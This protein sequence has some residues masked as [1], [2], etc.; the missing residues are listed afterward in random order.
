MIGPRPVLPPS[1]EPVHEYV[2]TIRPITWHE[3][4]GSYDIVIVGGGGHGLATAYYERHAALSA[5]DV[6]RFMVFDPTNPSS[7]HSCIASFCL[8]RPRVTRSAKTIRLDTK[9]SSSKPTSAQ[10]LPRMPCSQ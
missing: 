9:Q 6:L 4:R 5:D 3:P 10:S 2:T 7:I 8:T 1:Q